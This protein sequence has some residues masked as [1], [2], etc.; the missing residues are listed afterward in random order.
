MR[1]RGFFVF[2]S[3]ALVLLVIEVSGY[4]CAYV[5]RYYSGAVFGRYH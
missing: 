1:L 5:A 3:I 4:R 2:G